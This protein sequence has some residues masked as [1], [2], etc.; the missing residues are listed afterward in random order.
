MWKIDR[1]HSRG[2]FQIRNMLQIERSFQRSRFGR[3]SNRRI[4]R[5]RTPPIGNFTNHCKR[6][7]RALGNFFSTSEHA[8]GKRAPTRAFFVTNIFWLNIGIFFRMSMSLIHRDGLDFLR[9]DVESQPSKPV[10]NVVSRSFVAMLQPRD[11][12]INI[13]HDTVRNSS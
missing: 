8:Q 9:A 10:L 11:K 1:T 3:Q 2:F 12:A 5:A 4:A 13:K 7:C 6:H